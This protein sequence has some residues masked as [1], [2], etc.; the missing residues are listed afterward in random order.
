MGPSKLSFGRLLVVTLAASFALLAAPAGAQRPCGVFHTI[1]PGERCGAIRER[2]QL[3]WEEL[4]RLLD[5]SSPGMTCATLKAGVA[6][7][8]DPQAQVYALPSPPVDPLSLCTEWHTF[9]R[10]DACNTVRMKYGWTWP[11][12]NQVVVANSVTCATLE[13]G[14]RMCVDLKLLGINADD[15][16]SATPAESPPPSPPPP[17]L[18]RSPRP[19]PPPPSPPPPSPPPGEPVVRAAAPVYTRCATFH[20][21]AT[22][23]TCNDIRKAYGLSWEAWRAVVQLNPHVACANLA[24]GDTLCVDAAGELAPSPPP[25]APDVP[26][27]KWHVVQAGEVCNA[28]RKAHNLEWEEFSRLV[29]LSP[30]ISCAALIPDRDVICVDAGA[31]SAVLS[32]PP[33]PGADDRCGGYRQIQPGDTCLAIRESAGLSP[34]QFRELNSGLN[35]SALAVGSYLCIRGPS[36][37]PPSP[38]SP[39]PPR[40]PPP[41]PPSPPPPATPVRAEQLSTVSI[42]EALDNHNRFRRLHGVAD[43]IWRD[44]LAEAAQKW[45]D[46]CVFKHSDY[47]YGENLAL[48]HATL[49]DAIFAWYNEIKVYDYNYPVYSPETGHFTQIVWRN[50]QYIGCALGSCADGVALEGNQGMW[51]GRRR[52]WVCEYWP[53]GNYRGQF[54]YMVPPLLS[55]RRRGGV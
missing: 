29:A 28:V 47:P 6:L 55:K 54:S 52:L 33:P 43:L 37:P 20:R 4:P 34:L 36:L 18:P 35:C 8:V 14:M 26:C 50:T 27:T 24:E 31:T 19:S 25:P 2:Y 41:P 22:A 7:C 10:N 9:G 1:E 15:S 32:P 30:G 13:T 49:S 51:W 3:A 53:P 44:D 42:A 38:P 21:I 11:V 16:T 23:D 48:G 12:M 46:K 5:L 17:R 39:P 45:G 40:S